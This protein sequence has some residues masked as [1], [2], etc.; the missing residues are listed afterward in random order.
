MPPAQIENY[1]M[2]RLPLEILHEIFSY[3]KFPDVCLLNLAANNGPLAQVL[4]VDPKWG[5]ALRRVTKEDKA[6]HEE[7]ALF[8]VSP[9]GKRLADQF[10][11]RRLPVGFLVD[12]ILRS[13]ARYSLELPTLSY[14]VS[15]QIMEYVAGTDAKVLWEFVCSG[16]HLPKEVIGSIAPWLKLPREKALHSLDDDDA[17]D[18]GWASGMGDDEM[19]IAFFWSIYGTCICSY[20]EFWS[21]LGDFLNETWP[22]GDV[23]WGDCMCCGPE[24]VPPVACSVK[25]G[26]DRMHCWT[27]SEARELFEHFHTFLE[28]KPDKELAATSELAPSSR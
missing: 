20:L 15:W 2:E 24:Q 16:N 17:D 13:D 1:L 26:N 23:A 5:R 11:R 25:H 7:L 18:D 19:R 14:L 22:D 12:D 3:L 6:V 28:M 8:H 21:V 27:F 10:P 4:L 9:A